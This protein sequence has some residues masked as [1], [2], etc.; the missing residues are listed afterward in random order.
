MTALVVRLRW[1]GY[2]ARLDDPG[3][4]ASIRATA[5]RAGEV[6]IDYVSGPAA[7][8]RV[9]G[10]IAGYRPIPPGRASLIRR[11]DHLVT[12]TSPTDFDR[13]KAGAF[14]PT[15]EHRN[16]T[17]LLENHAVD[18][19]LLYDDTELADPALVLD[20]YRYSSA[21]NDTAFIRLHA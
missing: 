1:D 6:V 3:A 19:R 4:P 20:L 9:D 13:I 18:I 10:E 17:W 8:V 14:G 15:P 2:D 7:M 16:G 5:Q 12:T 21:I 11:L